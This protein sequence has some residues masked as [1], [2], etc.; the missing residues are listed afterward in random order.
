LPR[1]RA[2]LKYPIVIDGRNLYEPEHVAQSGLI[3]HSMGRAAAV[4]RVERTEER[5]ATSVLAKPT[6][7]SSSAAA[8]A[9]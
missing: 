9:L 1:L 7:S 6:I 3:Y 8:G 2:L 4:P 5:L